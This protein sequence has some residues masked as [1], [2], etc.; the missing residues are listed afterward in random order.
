[1]LCTQLLLSICSIVSPAPLQSADPASVPVEV[2]GH[3]SGLDRLGKF[4]LQ[5]SFVARERIGKDY[6]LRVAVDAW[7]DDY[8]LTDVPFK[9]PTSRWKVGR[10]VQL[11]LSLDLP[12]EG[13]AK[14]G[15]EVL[16]FV[17]FVDLASGA[18]TP[19][20][21]PTPDE[22]GYSE[23]ESIRLPGFLGTQGEEE[24]KGVIAEALQLKSKGD[25]RGAWLALEGGLRRAGDDD[26]KERF[27]DA[28]L[29]V[30]EFQPAE[31]S[32]EE[33]LIV[34][35]RISKEK[36]RYWRIIAGRMSS[37]GQLHGAM[38]LL[39]RTG[40]ALAEQADR[41]V[42]GAL[43]DA[44]R[45]MQRVD[46]IAQ[47]LIRELTPEQEALVKKLEDKLGFSAG[48]VKEAQA[49]ASRGEYPVALELMRRSHRS[50]DRDV[51][52]LAGELLPPMEVEWLALTPESEMEVVEA[53]LGHPSWERTTT[54]ATHAF[55]LIGPDKL[56]RGIPA[57]SKLNFD[58]AYV[59]L[60]D[61][62]G[63]K[64]NPNGDRV[65]VY[66]KELF[67][68]GGGIG[69]G[70]II[71]I[72]NAQSDPDKPVRVDTGLLYH[73]LTHCIDDTRPIFAGFREGL[74]NLGA[75]YAFEALDQDSDA[76]HSFDSN[77]EQFQK[78]FI[79]RD[80][81]YWRIQNYGPSAG[82]FL[83]FVDE[84]ASLS[85]ARHDW[86]PLRRFFRAYRDAPVHDGREPYIVRG[87][88]YYLVK[89]FGPRAFDDL[90]RFGFPLEERDRR[91]IGLEILAFDE[92]S[93]ELFEGSNDSYPTSPLPRDRVGKELANTKSYGR[94]EA[95]EARAAHGVISKWQTVGPFFTK[96]GDAGA[97]PF[98]PEWLIDFKQKVP[99]LRSTKDANTVLIWREPTGTWERA[100]NPA[101]TIDPGGWVKFDYE[102][103]GQ[104]DAAIY[105]VTSI[106]LK[107]SKELAVHVRADDDFS[108]F[109]D[110][111][112]I[113]AYRGRGRNGSSTNA[114]WRGPFKNLPDAQ[115]FEIELAAG[116]HSVL[117]KIKN[118]SGP[119]GLILA[120]SELDGSALDFRE[121]TDPVTPRRAQRDVKWKRI[122]R[123][124]GRKLKSKAKTTVGAFKTQ[125]KSL[126][127][128][129]T[130]KG[131]EW[132]RFTVRPGFPKDS[133]SNLMWLK[134]NV[135]D[136]ILDVRLELEIVR[137]SR[138]PKLLI[139]IQGEGEKDG[140][141]G[142]TLILVPVGSGHVSARLERYD[143]LVYETAALEL[144]EGEGPR[145]L[146]FECLDDEVS[147]RLDALQIFDRVP[148]L[149]IENRYRIGL[150]TWGTQ[151]GIAQ[152]TISAA[153]R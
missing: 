101:V 10:S 82:F 25:S 1:M 61:L 140:L 66:F 150:A 143:R 153:K 119:A 120:L 125:N 68:F 131:V 49:R 9:S 77:L 63:R 72:G 117:V 33:K 97:I 103:Y 112:R 137:E 133:P 50:D 34:A 2:R 147:V 98:E 99:A 110:G 152:F 13:Y 26:T 96:R 93:Y 22:D 128:S 142:W 135:T 102:P 21:Y 111:V 58:I 94:Q 71:D 59:F 113:G 95:S 32:T 55:L 148:I 74:A 123:L 79:D 35:S 107:E 64:P 17:T 70:K 44:K 118:R 69:G 139:T 88:A 11:D 51:R 65:T 146:T 84:Y 60:T 149:P 100:S 86:S 54:L 144:G 48:L 116:R 56:L 40:G 47:R 145:E 138:A 81:P 136:D 134:E 4:S 73:E 3:V 42:I 78:Y 151:P 90:V 18:A 109:V 87:L 130:D 121:D 15:D 129:D 12:E 80:L 23:V 83:H 45:T 67:D 8:S 29:K 6:K 108:L 132:R 91:A 14:I 31:L 7:A 92:G 46:D 43:G 36:I 114:S 75:A 20:E 104:R 38:R 105:A 57:S 19:L 122:A 27:R 126:Y 124:D 39:E 24:L 16:I 141:S 30:G 41:A 106:T 85:K 62:F 37:R 52:A 28:L 127:G 5:L 115:R 53:A 76:L 89:A